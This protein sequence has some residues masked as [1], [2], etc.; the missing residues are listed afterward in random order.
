[1]S[2]LL[3]LSL[4]SGLYSHIT[5]WVRTSHGHLTT[6]MAT[7]IPQYFLVPFS[8]LF[9]SLALVISILYVV[10]HLFIL[11]IVCLPWW[12]VNS[13]RA[14]IVV[15]FV[16]CCGTSIYN[17]AWHKGDLLNV[18][19]NLHVRN[20]SWHVFRAQDCCSSTDDQSL[21][22]PS[23]VATGFN[24]LNMKP[25]VLVPH[26]EESEGEISQPPSSGCW[27]SCPPGISEGRVRQCLP[28][29]V[30]GFWIFLLFIY[31]ME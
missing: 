5:F 16:H 6:E 25:S 3:T 21:H 9:S 14:G 28:Y 8:A 7:S 20:P 19:K 1:M 17:N 15:G 31:E 23:S 11:F 18:Y 27:N 2:V 30:F 26:T 29:L 10:F 4:P 22:R 12:N 24:S 13:R